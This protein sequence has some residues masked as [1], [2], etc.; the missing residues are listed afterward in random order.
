MA[1][2]DENV[3]QPDDV[4]EDQSTDQTGDDETDV[5]EEESA[6][7]D[8]DTDDDSD[9]ESDED[10]E[11]DAT[12]L[13]SK[14]RFDELKKDPE[15]LHKELLRAAN[16]KFRDAAE[17]RKSA[18][19]YAGFISALEENPRAALK[20]LAAKLGM[21][22]EG[23]TEAAVKKS[24]AD[25]QAEV[26][27][28]V[29][30]ALGD[31]YAELADKLVPAVKAIV[32]RATQ[33]ALK[34]IVDKQEEIIRDSA[35]RS[36]AQAM[37][38]FSKLRPDWKKHEPAMVKL[39]QKLPPGAGMSES[40]YLDILYFQVTRDKSTGDAVRRTVNRMTKSAGESKKT[41]GTVSKDK[42]AQRPTGTVSFKDAAAAAIRGERFE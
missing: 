34:P 21:T 3:D 31:D 13:I 35:M 23:D 5:D 25:A 6:G 33:V 32:D 37:E 12:E 29:R 38:Q 28:E 11:S 17:I 9:E 20:E 40:E 27:D 30:K 24:S 42:V 26:L 4:T 36:S 18:S 15:K 41:T 14:S 2:K 8:E 7:G 1:G 22:I 39:S 10:E 19:S 16:K